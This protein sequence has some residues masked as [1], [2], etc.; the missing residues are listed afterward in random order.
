MTTGAWY[1]IPAIAVTKP[2]VA[3][4][5]YAGAVEATPMT[6]LD[7]KPSAP[8]FSPFWSGGVSSPSIATDAT[9]LG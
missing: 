6:T 9:A 5:L 7:M 1:A 2:R 3:A 4:R 8:V